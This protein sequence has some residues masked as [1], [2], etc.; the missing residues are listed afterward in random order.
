MA[1][2][3]NVHADDGRLHQVTN[4]NEFV[5]YCMFSISFCVLDW[6]QMNAFSDSRMIR[7]TVFIIRIDEWN[8]KEKLKD[9]YRADAG[10]EKNKM[11]STDMKRYFEVY[12]LWI[13]RVDVSGKLAQTSST[14]I[15]FTAFHFH[16]NYYAT[17]NVCC[18]HAILWVLVCF[19]LT[20]K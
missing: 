4:E 6:H 1:C 11:I 15:T 2:R 10:T 12:Y 14:S 18:L 9:N 20:T 16:V 5:C 7:A 13:F 3:A 19:R 17:G 8:A